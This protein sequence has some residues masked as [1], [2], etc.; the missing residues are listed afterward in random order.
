MSKV[1]QIP[2]TAKRAELLI[3][4]MA[5]LP[6]RVIFSNHA[7]ERMEQRGISLADVSNVLCKGYVEGIP[8]I[9]NKPD[10]WK[11]KIVRHARGNRQIGVITIIICEK[12]IFIKTVEWEDL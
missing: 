11:C 7:I 4:S 6:H 2:L 9:A 5:D 3:H 10:E 12:K 8:E 1:F